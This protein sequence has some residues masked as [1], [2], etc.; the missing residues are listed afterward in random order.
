MREHHCFSLQF[1]LR[2]NEGY[3]RRLASPVAQALSGMQYLATHR[4]P[5]AAPSYDVIGF[6]KTRDDLDRVDAQILMAPW[7]TQP[8][9]P[10]KAIGLEREPGMQCIGYVL[11]PV[12]EGSVRITSLDPQAPAA[13]ET[14]YFDAAADRETGVR[15]FRKMREIFG[16]EPIASRL[17]AETQPGPTVDSDDDIIAAN[18]DAGPC[19]YHAIGTCAMGK[20]DGDVVDPDLRVR[21]VENLRVMDC[22]VLPVMVAGN[23]NAPMMAMASRAAEVILAAR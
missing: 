5:L 16:H 23:L 21:G 14:G 20:D 10:G 1:R 13:I 19:G 4:G 6:M 2:D 18:L 15:I 17:V 8:M 11:R 9:V 12:S 22:S 7:T 3:N